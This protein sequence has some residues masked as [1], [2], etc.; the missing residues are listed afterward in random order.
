MQKGDLSSEFPVI[1]TQ[2]E[3]ADIENVAREMAQNLDVIIEDI[4]YCMGEMGNGNY[5]VRTSAEEKKYTGDFEALL[6]SIRQMHRN[7]N[8]TFTP[9]R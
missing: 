3:V 2:D 5:T 4:K 9:D 8:D 7:M 6:L 1:D